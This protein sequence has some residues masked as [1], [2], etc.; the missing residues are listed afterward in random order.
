MEVALK[1]IFGFGIATWP[2]KG[3]FLLVSYHNVRKCEI[4]L[5][6]FNYTIHVHYTLVLMHLAKVSSSP[7]GVGELI[8]K[9]VYCGRGNAILSPR[10]PVNGFSEL[11]P[12]RTIELCAASR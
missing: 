11:W 2:E 10:Y 5:T 1:T 9:K 3:A 4:S 6:L 8:Q 7:V 12:G